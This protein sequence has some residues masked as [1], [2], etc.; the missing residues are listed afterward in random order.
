MGDGTWC[1]APSAESRYDYAAVIFAIVRVYIR[2]MMLRLLSAMRLLFRAIISLR[3]KTVLVVVLPRL[4]SVCIW[5]VG[6]HNHSARARRRHRR[7]GRS[8]SV[9]GSHARTTTATAVGSHRVG[10]YPQEAVAVQ[11][12]STLVLHVQHSDWRSGRAFCCSF[13]IFC[14]L[15]S[16]E[17]GSQ[18]VGAPL[19]TL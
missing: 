7:L 15:L 13:F 4:V 2:R 10:L 6:D 17:T 18:P 3:D 14:W 12:C 8:P 9:R 5:R 1:R 16:S 19:G 11:A